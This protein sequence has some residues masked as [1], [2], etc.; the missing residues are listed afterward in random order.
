MPCHWFSL[1]LIPILGPASLGLEIPIRVTEPAGL[2]RDA[3]PV[4]GGV[5]LPLDAV[6]W[7]QAFALTDQDGESVPVQCSALVVQPGGS[8]RWTL[9]DF[10]DDFEAGE[11]RRYTLRTVD[12]AAARP[13][14]RIERHP[15]GSM[16]IDTGA[17]RF[18]L[19]ADRNFGLFADVRR[20]DTQLLRGGELTYVQFH[21]RE[22]WNDGAAWSTREF[23]AGPPE[24]IEVV[25]AGAERVTVALRGGFTDDP[26]GAGW[27]TWITTWRGSSQVRVK[28]KLTNSNPDRYTLI[29]VQRATITLRLATARD[30][31]TFGATEP[32]TVPL[33]KNQVAALHAGLAAHHT[34]QDVAGH[35]LLRRGDEVLWRGDGPDRRAQGWLLSGDVLVVDRLFA[36]D[37]SRRLSAGLGAM[38]LDCPAPRFDGPRDAKFDRDRPVGQPWRSQARWLFDSSHLSSEY[39]F[40]FSGAADPEAVARR[41]RSRLRALAPPAWYSDCEALAVGRFGSLDDELA[42]YGKWGWTYDQ[43]KRPRAGTDPTAFVATEDNHYESE[44]DSV[45]ALLLM[46]LRSG[47]RGWFDQAEA[48]ARYHM[49]L[50]TWRTDGW[51][52]KDGGIWFPTGG[53]QGNR[54]VRASWNFAWG[55]PWADRAGNLDC[56]DLAKLAAAKSCYSA[57]TTG[58]GWPTTIA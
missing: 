23:V 26:L 47:E 40:D 34:H 57:T 27:R 50:Q 6:P 30:S 33:K 10:Q 13:G 8:L 1:I 35:T 19:D 36:A 21:G 14:V 46:H 44:A 2:A 41:S 48:W 43:A 24:A 25:H 16:S 3:A 39:C 45:Q 7:D 29:P 15:N 52:W 37:P 18:R 56:M 53:P 38:A 31:A 32:V 5:P 11:T 49:D 55:Q 20:G 28:H 54:P 17:V 12:K 51:R 22:G 42:A 58:R 4:S 9:L